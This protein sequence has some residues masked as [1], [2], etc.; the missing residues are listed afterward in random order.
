MW[1]AGREVSRE[2]RTLASDVVLA[3]EEAPPTPTVRAGGIHGT[4]RAKESLLL[5][6][7]RSKESLLL[8]LNR[9]NL[10]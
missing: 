1:R 10:Y 5:D 3:V 6:L 8:D 4:D 7:N 2:A 9:R